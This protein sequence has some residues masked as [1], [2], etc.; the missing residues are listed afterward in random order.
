M[1]PLW[2]VPLLV[3]Q[4]QGCHAL[5]V[6]YLTSVDT[7]CQKAGV[8]LCLVP[9][10]ATVWLHGTGGVSGLRLHRQTGQTLIKTLRSASCSCLAVPHEEV[11]HMLQ[12]MNGV[13]PADMPQAEEFLSNIDLSLRK[14][15]IAID[16]K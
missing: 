13:A 11:L 3:L 15:L 14:S 9:R 2:R 6:T 1:M 7:A 10:H 4:G 8:N 12:V 16:L 5:Q